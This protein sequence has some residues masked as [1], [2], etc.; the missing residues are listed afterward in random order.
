MTK[1]KATLRRAMSPSGAT[2]KPLIAIARNEEVDTIMQRTRHQTRDANESPHP[3]CLGQNVDRRVRLRIGLAAIDDEKVRG[4]RVT[5]VVGEQRPTH[6]TLHGYQTERGCTLWRAR[7]RAHPLHMLQYPSNTSRRAADGGNSRTSGVSLDNTRYQRL[8]HQCSGILR[9]F[10]GFEAI[11]F[12][13]GAEYTPLEDRINT[14]IDQ[15]ISG[16]L[17]NANVSHLSSDF[18]L[19]R[20]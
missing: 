18:T 8:S 3:S 2:S 17:G 16:W 13:R 12:R 10:V 6:L 20:G 5:T 19:P 9:N 4:Q 14:N 15:R 1:A 11:E 7:N